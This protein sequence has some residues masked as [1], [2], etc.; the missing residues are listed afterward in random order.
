ML[1]ALLIL[2]AISVASLAWLV[3]AIELRALRSPPMLSAW[4]KREIS[5][6]CESATLEEGVSREEWNRRLAERRARRGPFLSHNEV[7][8]RIRERQ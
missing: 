2:T 5:R 8:N 3:R 1:F 7:R 4:A 6:A